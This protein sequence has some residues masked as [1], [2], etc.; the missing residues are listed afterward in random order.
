[1]KK[2]PLSNSDKVF[3]DNNLN[4]TANQLSDRLSRS[5]SSVQN[6]LDKIKTEHNT[7]DNIDIAVNKEE[8]N[9]LNLYAR[10]KDR[11]VVIMT[12]NASTVS[13][14]KRKLNN[15]YETRKYR[16]VIHK[17]KED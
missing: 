1:M 5:L 6:Y 2:G 16:N 11:G 17:I 3:I 9:D 8:S 14:E 12:E 13:D 15:V 10:N 4:M 7:A